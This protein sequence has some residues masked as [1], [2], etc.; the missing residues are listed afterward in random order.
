MRFLLPTLTLVLSLSTLSLYAATTEEKEEPQPRGPLLP[1]SLTPSEDHAA[2]ELHDQQAALAHFNLCSVAHTLPPTQSPLLNLNGL[3][4]Y[5]ALLEEW[6]LKLEAITGIPGEYQNTL[7]QARESVETTLAALIHRLRNVR[8]D[9]KIKHKLPPH[10]LVITD[11]EAAARH[12][13]QQI[14]WD[15]HPQSHGLLLEEV[16][17]TYKKLLFRTQK[18]TRDLQSIAPLF[19]FEPTPS[20]EEEVPQ[21]VP[22][23][24]EVKSPPAEQALLEEDPYTSLIE[25]WATQLEISTPQNYETISSQLYR[26]A[27]ERLSFLIA[28]ER[29]L[30]D[31]INAATSEEEITP[32]DYHLTAQEKAIELLDLLEEKAL[33][34]PTLSADSVA[35]LMATMYRTHLLKAFHELEK[36][37]EALVLARNHLYP[38][39]RALTQHSGVPTEV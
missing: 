20:D 13:G 26:D 10:L 9:L 31:Q 34:G 7:R 8:R 3:D 30:N 27:V 1:R 22:V 12:L 35:P 11:E 33:I 29:E 39:P 6:N 25:G 36:R 19:E 14:G 37:N 2:G 16:L 17:L 23:L 38:V 18:T 32:Q 5:A 28:S 21:L 4:P 24:P 15:R